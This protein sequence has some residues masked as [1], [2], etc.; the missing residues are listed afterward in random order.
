MWS[1]RA[2][3]HRELVGYF[4]W[5]GAAVLGECETLPYEILN[6][7]NIKLLDAYNVGGGTRGVGSD[8]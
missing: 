2:G 1:G 3:S 5:S 6:A 7:F 4:T 8:I